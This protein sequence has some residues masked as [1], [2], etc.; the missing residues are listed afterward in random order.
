[1]SSFHV[2]IISIFT[3][4]LRHY[5]GEELD[6]LNQRD[7]QNLEQQLAIALKN[8]RFRKN[9][10]LYESISELQ[11]KEKALQEQNY[12]LAKQIKEKEKEMVQQPHWDQQNHG[13]NMPT[14]S[15]ASQ[16]P[17]LNINGAYEG[18]ATEDGRING[19]DLNM[20]SLYSCHLGCFPA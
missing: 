7:L 9:Q 11:R 16:L 2:V 5:M 15:M 10:L 6:S 19:L 12:M 1:M 20:D 14:F 4:I 18:V 8:I 13:N 3:C 17:C